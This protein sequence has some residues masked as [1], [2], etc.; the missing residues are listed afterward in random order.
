MEIMRLLVTGPV[1]AGKSTFIQAVGNLYG[2]ETE[3]PNG[4][5]APSINDRNPAPKDFGEISL[6]PNQVLHLYG[7]PGQLQ[8]NLQWETLLQ[9][10]HACL[11]LVSANRPGK[12]RHARWL[13]RWLQDQLALP[14]VVG[15]T[16]TD[17]VNAWDVDNVALALGLVDETD[18]IPVLR[19]NLKDQTSV[20]DALLTLV[21]QYLKAA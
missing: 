16:N 19:I 10:A 18:C 12:F 6:G 13:H 7:L 1:G 9:K 20:R 21:G 14:V 5:D 8:R 4:D 15:L 11:L 3:H 2:L 17:G